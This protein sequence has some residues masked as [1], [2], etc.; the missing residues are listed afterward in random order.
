MS[1]FAAVEIDGNEGA[2]EASTVHA[3]RVKRL[4]ELGLTSPDAEAVA[5]SV[6]WHDVARLVERGCPAALAVAILN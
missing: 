1:R 2:A 6:D 3:W 5:D 4:T